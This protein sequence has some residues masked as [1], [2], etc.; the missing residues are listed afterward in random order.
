MPFREMVCPNLSCGGSSNSNSSDNSKD[1]AMTA[2][3]MGAINV[4]LRIN[5]YP[6]KKLMRSIVEGIVVTT[7]GA[8]QCQ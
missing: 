1:S 8:R 3:M 2:A 4:L 7:M 6:V 5:L